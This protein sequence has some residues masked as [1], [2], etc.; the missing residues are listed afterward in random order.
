MN[1]FETMTKCLVTKSI[2][3][4]TS[5]KQSDKQ[6][7]YRIPKFCGLTFMEIIFKES[8]AVSMHS[9]YESE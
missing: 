2:C 7:E 5:L 8:L 6:N 4:W 9:F 1:T 3:I